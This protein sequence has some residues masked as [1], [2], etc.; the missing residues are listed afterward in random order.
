MMFSLVGIFFVALISWKLTEFFLPT[1]ESFTGETIFNATK[2]LINGIIPGEFSNYENFQTA[3]LSSKI[4]VLF[5]IFFAKLL[6]N[7]TF[8]G[9]LSAGQILAPTVSKI[10]V[11]LITFLII[12]VVFEIGLKF[13]RLFLSKIIKNCGLSFGNRVL[14]GIIGLIRGMFVFGV[15]YVVISMV[16]NILLSEGLLNFIKNGEISNFMYHNFIEKIINLFY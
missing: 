1:V 10:F 5:N 15:F 3:V 4:G 8:E 11:R 13:L 12:L 6:E 16:A 14:G 9:N 7:I 2:S